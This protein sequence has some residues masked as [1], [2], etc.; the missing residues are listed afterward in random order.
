MRVGLSLD[1]PIIRCRVRP[2]QSAPSY[3]SVC[4]LLARRS[5]PYPEG[6]TC[7][8]ALPTRRRGYGSGLWLVTA[9]FFL[10]DSRSMPNCPLISCLREW[11]SSLV[12]W[13]FVS[14]VRPYQLV[15][16]P[17]NCPNLPARWQACFSLRPTL[18]PQDLRPTSTSAASQ[19]TVMSSS[20]ST[21]ALAAA[22]GSP[23][24]QQLIRGN[25]LIWKALVTPTDKGIDNISHQLSTPEARLARPNCNTS[26]N[27]SSYRMS[28]L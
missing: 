9:H 8:H 2:T 10:L 6:R 14:C 24:T 22:L 26:R 13:Y 27:T 3:C 18:H 11:C 21:S 16:R 19:V 5:V 20:S 25:F 17:F 7:G 28:I 12:V 15:F 1:T 23:P 4:C